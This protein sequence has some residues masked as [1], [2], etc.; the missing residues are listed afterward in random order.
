M[1]N[2]EIKSGD[3]VTVSL[4]DNNLAS[5]TYRVA[6]PPM[7]NTAILFHPLTGSRILIAKPLDELNKVQANLKDSTERSLEYARRNEEYLDFNTSAEL[8]ALCLYFLV[9]RSL[10]SRQKR[11]LSNICGNIASIYFHNDIS[12][13]MRYIVENEGVLND[14]NRMWYDNFKGL[15]TNAQPITSNKQRAS[16]FNIAGF[17]LAELESQKVLK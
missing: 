9:H 17:V 6:Y 15:F 4:E 2:E 5:N 1:N 3:L 11:T 8:E 14:F 16:L 12:L 10:A 7:E 13:A